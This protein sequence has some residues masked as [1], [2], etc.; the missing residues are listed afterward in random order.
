MPL[1]PGG[2][3][4]CGGR[5]ARLLR[6][7]H[8]RAAA[9]GGRGGRNA[10]D[11][12]G[13]RGHAGAPAVRCCDARHRA[14]R[15]TPKYGKCKPTG[16]YNSVK[17]KTV[18]RRH[19]HCRL[20]T[21]APRD[22]EGQ[23]ARHRQRRLQLL[24]R[25]QHRVARGA[26]EDE[27]QQGR[28]RAARDRPPL[29]LRHRDGRHLHQARARGEDRLLDP[30]RRLV[31]G[32]LAAAR[33]TPP[34]R[35]SLK[36]L[37]FAVTLGS[38]QQAWVENVLKAD[39]KPN[40]YD[41]TVELFAALRAKQ[42]D[43][44]AIDMPG[45]PARR[46]G[47]QRRRQ[48][49]RPG[50]GRRPGGHRHGAGQSRTARRSTRSSGE[51]KERHAQALEK[52]YY[53]ASYGG[54]DPDKLP[55]GGSTS[56]CRAIRRSRAGRRRDRGRQATGAPA[57]LAACSRRSRCSWSAVVALGFWICGLNAVRGLETTDGYRLARRTPSSVVRGA[58]DARC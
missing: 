26:L 32:H 48:G 15:T 35:T 14:E 20:R 43:A 45:R 46:R 27:L 49:V 51:L 36:D 41:D 19:A 24:L 23:H 52:K 6:R 25:G 2:L 16:K 21:I 42:V 18:K 10:Q 56:G 54:V 31:D 37:K 55:T 34:R 11:H 28:L 29:G 50:Q 9:L 7:R 8:R 12:P 17:L 57:A 13:T 30:L 22:V 4:R 53:F 38:V 1:G 47:V 39:Q 40:T 5:T 33:T 3:W 44:V 58:R